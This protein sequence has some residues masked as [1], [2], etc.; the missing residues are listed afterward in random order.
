MF[1][2]FLCHVCLRRKKLKK[3]LVWSYTLQDPASQTVPMHVD[4]VFRAKGWW[5]ASNALLQSLVQLSTDACVKGNII[6]YPPIEHKFNLEEYA[7]KN[8]AIN[9][10]VS[11]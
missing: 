1:I 11:T 6:M 4:H 9:D 10:L 8:K 2:Q 3:Y 5:W 7:A